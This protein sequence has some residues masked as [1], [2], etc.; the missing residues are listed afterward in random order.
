MKYCKGCEKEKEIN[1]FGKDKNKKDGLNFYC[2]LCISERNKKQ[3][4]DSPEKIKR[5]AK[6]YREI[7]KDEI[8][9]WHQKYYEENREKILQS[10]RESYEKHKKEI[11]LRRA[12]NRRTNEGR[13]KARQYGKKSR[14]KTGNAIKYITK[15]KKA[16]PHKSAVHTFVLWAVRVGVMKKSDSCQN[17]GSKGKI[18]GHHSDYDKPMEVQWLCSICHGEKHRKL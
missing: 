9:D 17:C 14:D 2:K 1:E 12:L 18:Q 7:H 4:I 3:K 15:W 8:K 6:K 11:A 5:W 13:L 16:N 10:N